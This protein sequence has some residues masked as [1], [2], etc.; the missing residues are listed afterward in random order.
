GD[1]A[2]EVVGR[3]LVGIGANRLD[4][5]PIT[6]FGALDHDL[7]VGIFE[8]DARDVPRLDVQDLLGRRFLVVVRAVV[9]IRAKQQREN[10]Y[11]N[12]VPKA[13][14]R[15]RWSLVAAFPPDRDPGDQEQLRQQQH[16]KR[17]H[18]TELIDGQPEARSA[19]RART[20]GDGVFLTRQPIRAVNEEI[21]VKKVTDVLVADKVRG[22]EYD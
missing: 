17:K 13:H 9:G 3:G 7:T 8:V 14:R 10:Q 11:D 12:R 16:R 15:R 6:A 20:N 18:H 19:Q 22:A 4:Y 2:C 5:P 1:R 21:A